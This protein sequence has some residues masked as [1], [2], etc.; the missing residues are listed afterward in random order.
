MSAVHQ[1]CRAA[2]AKDCAIV[3]RIEGSQPIVDT[4]CAQAWWNT[5]LRESTQSE[6]LASLSDA[7]T[8]LAA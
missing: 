7:L 6:S 1:R 4:S 8:P 2:A 3:L 5:S